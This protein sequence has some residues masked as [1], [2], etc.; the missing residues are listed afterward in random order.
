M[1]VCVCVCVCA[2]SPTLHDVIVR[3]IKVCQ[4]IVLIQNS[5][6]LTIMVLCCLGPGS[7]QCRPHHPEE[8]D[9]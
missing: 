5:H 7:D 8:L 1:C 6:F 3:D 4:V 9:G 2:F